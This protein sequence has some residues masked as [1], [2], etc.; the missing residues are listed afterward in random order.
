MALKFKSPSR[1]ACG[2]RGMSLIEVML[3]LLIL[4][5]G[6]L[7]VMALVLTAIGTNRANR[8]QSNATAIA[9]MIMEKITSVPATQSPTLSLSD[10]LT[11]AQN[12]ATGGAAGPAGAGA[13]LYTGSSNPLWTG[14]IDFSQAIASVP[15]SYSMQYTLCGSAGR[16]TTY[17]VRW[18][19]IT[20][21]SNAK[22][23]T[24]SVR[25][26]G[27]GNDLKIFAPPVTVRTIAGVGT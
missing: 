22:L 16:Q 6:V 25:E 1:K 24:V 19:V 9:Q 10:C 11:G 15:A 17:D 21:T 12:I 4:I 8:Q 14:G 7:G 20:L 23:I 27:S 5:V 26:R 18:N 2:Q 3:A 13:T